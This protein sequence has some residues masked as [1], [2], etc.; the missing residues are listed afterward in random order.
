MGVGNGYN[1]PMKNHFHLLFAIVFA[2]HASAATPDEFA[3]GPAATLRWRSGATDLCCLAPMLADRSWKFASTVSDHSTSQPFAFSMRLGDK[4]IGGSFTAGPADDGTAI[5][6]AWSFTSPE[7]LPFGEMALSDNFA[8]GAVAGG[9]WSIGEKSG[10][11]PVAYADVTVASATGD[12]LV[13]TPPA[14]LPMEFVFPEPLHVLLQD[15]RRWGGQNFSVR[16][17]KVMGEL[18]A[19]VPSTIR[20]RIPTPR[21]ATYSDDLP[22]RIEAGSDWIPLA[23]DP[24]ILPGSALDFSPFGF[25]RAGC[26]DRGRIVATPEGH[27]A[28][29][30]APD[31]P[32]RFYGVNFCFSAQYLTH[33]ETD[34]LLDRLVRLGYNTVRIHHYESNLTDPEW[35]SGWDWS[36]DK[37]DRLDYFIDGCAKRGLWVTTDLYVSRP[38]PGKE[39]GFND[40]RYDAE[41]FK[42]LVLIN[43]VAFQDY[44]RFAK[45]F[46]GRVNPYTGHSLAEEPALAWISLVN[47][48]G[49]GM[50]GFSPDKYPE[51]KTRWNAWLAARHGEDRDA[52]DLAL[53]DLRDDEDPAKGNVA[54]PSNIRDGS[55]RS[56]L[57][58]VFL[59]DIERDFFL[60]VKAYL[61]DELRCNA[62][63][64]DINCGGTRVPPMHRARAEFDY[65]DEHFYVDHPMMGDKSAGII[66]TCQGSNPVR[67]GALG[68]SERAA[69][70]VWGKPF[71]VS[72]YN[73][74]SPA[75]YRAVGG[76]ITAAMAS[77]QDWDALWRF[78]YAHRAEFIRKTS[79]M[80]YF[81]LVSDPLNQAS[82][83]LATLLFLRG[84]IAPAP[85]RIA[86]DLPLDMLEAPPP[87][88]GLAGL[89]PL[90]WDAA[91]GSHLAP[92]TPQQKKDGATTLH[93]SA[94]NAANPDAV[95]A[96]FATA[97]PPEKSPITI[98]RANGVF[99]IDTP[100]FAGGYADPGA[101]I[102]APG[103]G[104]TVDIV[105]TG[106]TVGI[107]SL[108]GRPLRT[109]KRILLTHL[110]D[111]QNSGAAFAE[112]ARR[113]LTSWGE[114]PY[115]VLRG[116]ARVELEHENPATLHVWEIATNGRH[117]RELKPAPLPAP[118]KG[119]S[120]DLDTAGPDGARMYYE[121]AAE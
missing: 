30:K 113:T 28:E 109:S 67:D 93:V 86:A 98:D 66:S 35:K 4:S 22:V 51:W 32:V 61:R 24:D 42:Q 6:A 87:R 29:A 47:E 85:T 62:L 15:N 107:A 114:P 43:D 49:I 104:V 94:R 68:G 97:P 16:I 52:L 102:P 1:A 23:Y 105:K 54:F 115:L 14:G 55:R 17:G 117:V 26:G 78:A 112:S 110:T 83:R 116:T 100:A 37:L 88:I 121:I 79:S 101:R 3:G 27:F 48:G 39:I 44:L 76:L 31:R 99:A 7:P 8:I 38:V 72:E 41:R 118:R 73:Y 64:T 65:V 5:E 10:V 77:R 56:R 11:F 74:A 53:G 18:A 36:P 80:A 71:T 119:L 108:D 58:Q 69:T 103:A 9:S 81:D 19:N 2:L 21:G 95:R 20:I 92:P 111:L 57:C 50:G 120:I 60:R 89:E 46:L 13:I 91:V 96:A 33:D 59:S 12:R 70:R 25:A 45:E 63:L 40:D 34:R 90:V 106:A 84:D 75:R 82:D